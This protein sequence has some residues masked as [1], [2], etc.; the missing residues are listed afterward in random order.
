M[1]PERDGRK[2]RQH[3]PAE[4]FHYYACVKHVGL[5]HVQNAFALLYLQKHVLDKGSAV[6]EMVDHLATIDMGRKVGAAVPLFRELGP[7]LHNV[8]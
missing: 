6:A 8:V 3:E 2:W 5:L 7:H 1:I 4:I